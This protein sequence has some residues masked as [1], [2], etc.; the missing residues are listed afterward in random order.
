V[1]IAGLTGSIAMGK[2][3]TSRMF[4]ELCIPVFDADKAVHELYAVGGAAVASVGDLFPTVIFENAIDREALGKIVLGDSA[5]M[6]NLEAIVHP[7]VREVREEFL[8]NARLAGHELV[9]LDIPLLFE[10]GYDV[11]LDAVI[12]VSAPYELQRERVLKR[13]GMT[14][15]KFENILARQTPD[16]EKRE[17]ADYVVDSNQGLEHAFGQV[18][19]IVQD[20]TKH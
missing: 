16:A 18:R 11:H 14:I 15:E 13:P 8:S 1:K 10:T 12:V 19:Q 17:K 9:V 20:L 7:L 6:K 4:R 3:E 2:S 5:A